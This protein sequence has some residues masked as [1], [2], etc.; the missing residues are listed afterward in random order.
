MFNTNCFIFI[1][2]MMTRKGK[3][4]VMLACNGILAG[5]IS[6]MAGC[7]SSII[8]LNLNK[9]TL[10]LLRIKTS[11]ANNAIIQANMSNLEAIITGGVGSL[12]ALLGMQIIGKFFIHKYI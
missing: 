1:N 9:L 6:V 4:E 11:E 3:T 10:L 2:S 12:L 8:H 5:I 7:V